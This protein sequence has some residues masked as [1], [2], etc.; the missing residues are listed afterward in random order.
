MST[1]FP[2]QLLA[3]LLVAALIVP[4]PILAQGQPGSPENASNKPGEGG[5]GTEAP[6]PD[7]DGDGASDAAE[8]EAAAA[9]QAEISAAA[10]IAG[11]EVS[12]GSIDSKDNPNDKGGGSVTVDGVA[13]SK[14]AAIEAIGAIADARDNHGLNAQ[15][16]WAGVPGA[17]NNPGVNVNATLEAHAQG[18]HGVVVGNISGEVGAPA[19][20]ARAESEI[21]GREAAVSPLSDS[22]FDA[23]FGGATAVPAADLSGALTAAYSQLA[24][25]A[26]Q[27]GVLSLS[28]STRY[29]PL[30][31]AV[32]TMNPNELAARQEYAASL[33][34]SGNLS[35]SGTTNTS[36]TYNPQSGQWVGN[37]NGRPVG[38]DSLPTNITNNIDNLTAMASQNPDRTFTIDLNRGY[39]TTLDRTTGST[40]NINPVTGNI[41][42]P[43]TL[44]DVAVGQQWGQSY[45][46]PRGTAAGGLNDASMRA[47]V[48]YASFNTRPVAYTEEELDYAARVMLAESRSIRNDEKGIN[49]AALQAVADVMAARV[50]SNQFPNTLTGVIEQPFQFQPV[51]DKVNFSQFS[52]TEVETAKAIARSV[53]E[54]TAVPVAVNKDKTAQMYFANVPLTLNSSRASSDTKASVAAMKE[55]ENSITFYSSTGRGTQHTF[56]NRGKAS[57]VS[58]DTGVPS[59]YGANTF[60]RP[61]NPV[62]PAPAGGAGGRSATPSTGNPTGNAGTVIGGLIGGSV[63]A[64]VGGFIGDSFWSMWSNESDG[65][66]TPNTTP[67]DGCSAPFP[68]SCSQGALLISSVMSPQTVAA[69]KNLLN[70]LW[71]KEE[72]SVA[73]SSSTGD[74][75]ATVV[76]LLSHNVDTGEIS[77][78]RPDVVEAIENPGEYDSGV[79]EQLKKL[80]DEDPV[81]FDSANNIIYSN[82]LYSPPVKDGEPVMDERTPRYTYALEY[83]D[84]NG[85]PVAYERNNDADGLLTSM[86]RRLFGSNSPF[87]LDDVT[88]ATYRFVDPDPE[89]PMDEFYDYVFKLNDGEVRGITVPQFSSVRHMN[90]RFAL[91]GYQGSAIKLL[92]VAKET[93][94]P[95][96]SALRYIAEKLGSVVQ[97]FTAPEADDQITNLPD[98]GQTGP[99]NIE[100]VFI[101]PITD[102][103]CP[104]G[105]NGYD[106]GFMFTANVRDQENPDY[107]ISVTDGRCGYG[108]MADLL[109]ETAGYLT[110]EYGIENV[111][112]EELLPKTSFI[113]EATIYTPGVVHAY[114]PNTISGQPVD[115][116]PAEP[117]EP[118]ATSTSNGTTRPNLTNTITFEVKVVGSGGSVASNW[119]SAESVTIDT[120]DQLHFR[121]NGTDYGQCLPF[122]NDNGNYA[123]TVRNQAM[124]TGDTESE[125]YNVNERSGVY[126]VEC[127]GQRNNEYGVDSREIGVTVR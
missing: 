27:A 58:Y 55:D 62:G 5:E 127:G 42:D 93:T 29:D 63:G 36:F 87:Y 64:A 40:I 77:I 94:T 8:A 41:I 74:E 124:V 24:N 126:R 60:G 81:L 72:S 48:T 65:G 116:E 115:N 68:A 20:V 76:V 75:P 33:S 78:S 22:A 30:S 118:T 79:I 82:G 50:H 1:R 16:D 121:W 32:T 51:L 53:F 69:F 18:M 104:A 31:G 7:A 90:E 103:N 25:S 28:G 35:L 43:V 37:Q 95:P 34:R 113:A 44:E 117:S 9:A 4:T 38:I 26:L 89:V 71:T 101:Y 3:F 2:A 19:A 17:Q 123:L 125:G 11:V 12:V 23:R 45:S 83:V 57:D 66:T 111:S 14:E 98:F 91:V 15:P 107:V 106:G 109:I 73:T 61:E 108:D 39:V 88:E 21:A 100:S 85:E 80:T 86:I 49:T 67:T 92:E 99:A 96:W 70:G 59:P 10:G 112:A 120:G 47:A 13:M 102:I 56:G 46:G 97:N 119:S 110:Q 122:L 105:V 6:D 84:Q 114:S 54:A 52:R